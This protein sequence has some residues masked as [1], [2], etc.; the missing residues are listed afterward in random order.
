M[1]LATLWLLLTKR[2]EIMLLLIAGLVLFAAGWHLGRVMSPYYAAHP[3]IFQEADGSQASAS[4]DPAA[5][6]ALQDEGTDQPDQQLAAPQSTPSTAVA[7]TTTDTDT[8]QAP[9]VGEGSG[10]FV[11]SVNSDLY[12][13]KDCTAWLRIKE[14]NRV[15][16]NTKE[17]A[18]KAGYG[19]S[20]CTT[21]KL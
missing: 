9:T 1:N 17:D 2:S 20:K 13:H 8:T 3:L 19:P 7:G 15:W 4:S 14:E 12:H 18:E 21:E 10:L 16:F 6:L 5:L 11:A